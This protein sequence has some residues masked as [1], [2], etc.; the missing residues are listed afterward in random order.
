MK[1]K[2]PIIINYNNHIKTNPGEHVYFNDKLY[3][4]EIDNFSE[5]CHDC[6]FDVDGDCLITTW[7]CDCEKY[8]CDNLIFKLVKDG[9]RKD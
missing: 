6:D 9:C 2:K 7:Q 3:I 4:C 1:I 8:N 5:G